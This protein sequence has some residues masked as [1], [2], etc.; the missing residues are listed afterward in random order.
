MHYV[1]SKREID[2]E[3]SVLFVGSREKA[4]AYYEGFI[5]GIQQ[6]SDGNFRADFKSVTSKD[7]DIDSRIA[8]IRLVH[9]SNIG[10]TVNIWITRLDL[11]HAYNYKGTKSGSS[12]E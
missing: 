2:G 3:S 1:I 7:P 5:D 12:S 11:P 10:E 6:Y 4:I 9:Q 8:R